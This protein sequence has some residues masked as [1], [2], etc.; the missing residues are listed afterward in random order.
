MQLRIPGPTPL[1]D[2]VLEAMNRNMISHRGAEFH[3]LM[4]D[5]TERLKVSF[6]TEGDVLVF[7]GAGT[8]GLEASIVNLFS[9]GDRIVSVTSGAF[10][11]RYAEIAAHFG[12]NVVRVASEWGEAADLS[13]LERALEETPGVKG[14]LMT[15]NETSTG[16]QNDVENTAKILRKR[17]QNA[18]LLLVDAVSSLGAVD[19]PVDKWEIDVA[20]TASQ[21]AWM[22]PPGLTMLSVSERAWEASRRAQLPRF[23]WDFAEA[24]RYL[25]KYETPYTPALSLLFGLQ[26]SLHLMMDE[27]LPNVFARHERLRDMVRDGARSRGF[28]PFAPDAIASRTITALLPPAG[29]PA[30]EVVT[31]MRERGIIIASGQGAYEHKLIRIGHMGFARE[32]DM[33]EVLKALEEV[34]DLHPA[35]H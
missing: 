8:G 26:A 10:G 27:G 5:V 20:I 13:G 12:L 15:H 29:V 19:I 14:V 33:Q 31:G 18:P 30:K 4:R 6:Q 28:L 23:Y 3:A 35:V 21:K 24:K 2:E 32:E 16:V 17:G 11:D 7:P 25:D 1:P 34:L 22:A 9:P